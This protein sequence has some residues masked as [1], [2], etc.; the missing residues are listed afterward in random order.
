MRPPLPDKL[1][2]EFA[3]TGPRLSKF[4]ILPAPAVLPRLFPDEA[5]FALR[6]SLL[7]SGTEFAAW[8]WLAA[9]GR[10]GVVLVL[11]LLRALRPLWAF[12]GARAPRPLVA[13]L[14]LSF[15]LFAFCAT[16]LSPVHPLL[17]L[18][19]VAAGL[20]ALG[21]L[22][23]SCIADSVTVERRATAYA[24]LDMGQ[25]LGA[26][27]GFA[28][29][30]AFGGFGLVIAILALVVAAAGIPQLHHRGTPRS[31]W[32][33]GSYLAVARTP[34]AS[35]L[36]ALAFACGLCA[37]PFSAPRWMALVLPI[38]GMALAARLEPRLPN[39][40][41]LPRVALGLSLAGFVLT[42][43][44]FLG[45]GM[46]FA[47]I[48]ASVARGAGEMERPLASSLA[49]SALIAGAACAAVL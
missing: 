41:W 46:M 1:P 10:R 48:P 13:L 47:A 5:R 49:W 33:L 4:P 21:D 11:A 43:L 16:V 44:R 38:A 32:P 17:G 12:F 30:R 28:L 35:Q 14:P 2:E 18:A 20:P 9:S 36:A 26:A 7:A 22:C 6:L 34:L 37:P 15:A 24:F 40:I 29:G 27:F 25:G 45:L 42:P 8:A 3:P 23:A 19:A 31:S 39:A